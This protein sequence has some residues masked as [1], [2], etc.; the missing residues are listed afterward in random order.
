MIEPAPRAAIP[1]STAAHSSRAARTLTASSAST[2]AVVSS[3]S[4]ALI[5]AAALL[6]RTSIRP[7][8]SRM[9][10]TTSDTSGP[11]RSAAA[12]TGS[13]LSPAAV[14]SRPALSLASRTTRAPARSSARAVAAPMPR[15]APV[16]NATRPGRPGGE[17]R[18]LRP[19]RVA[20]TDRP[21]GQDVRVQP[22]AV[23]HLLDDPWPRQALQVSAWLAELDA[24]AF[25]V[26]DPEP[27]SH[28]VVDP[29]AADHDLA[30]RLGAGEADIGKHLSL[31]QRQRL[32]R[33]RAIVVEVPVALQA[34]ACHGDHRIYRRDRVARP[35]VDLLHPH[36]TI[37]TGRRRAGQLGFPSMRELLPAPRL[38]GAVGPDLVGALAASYAYPDR[39]WVRANMIAS[40]DG[41][42]S[43]DGRSGGLSG[44][45]DRL[46]FTVLR[47]LAD[48]ILVGA[49][50]ARAERYGKARPARLWPQ[51]RRG[52]PPAPPV[53]VV[54]RSLDLDPA[55]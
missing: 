23:D 2:W 42:V 36:P 48:V 26:A 5:A 4:G 17:S 41:A 9:G 3:D 31:D 34:L 14:R 24:H 22:G 32:T 21:I 55:S 53:A 45:A 19:D 15:L 38:L 39:L 43:L 44:P 49:G 40:V 51:L 28:Q 35:D 29:D 7:V 1:G 33:F 13:L 25:H 11:R 52:R 10:A 37:M 8:C 54:T 20:D 27:P 50:T 30:P 12:T 46:L 47:S 16:T 6:T 18:L